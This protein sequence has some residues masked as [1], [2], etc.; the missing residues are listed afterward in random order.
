MVEKLIIIII[1][2][3]NKHNIE[4]S[5]LLASYIFNQCFPTSE[6]VKGYLITGKMYCL[7]VW[8]KHNNKRY[9]IGYMQFMRNYY[10][11]KYLPPSQLSMEKPNHLENFDDNYEEFCSQLQI[12][13]RETYYNN[14]PH[15]VK[16][17]IKAFERK[18]AKNSHRF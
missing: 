9:D 14:A 1:N 16:K 6:I 2:E 3:L 13:K 4:K 18:Y 17:C 5:C 15:N 8:F 7:H 12:F 11:A 10:Y